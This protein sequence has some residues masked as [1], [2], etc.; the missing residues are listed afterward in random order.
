[1]KSY[2][3]SNIIPNEGIKNLTIVA[4][5]AGVIGGGIVG[6]ISQFFYLILL[7]P[8]VMGGA[9]GTAIAMTAKSSKVRN[10]MVA[11]L[12]G[13]LTAFITYA[14]MNYVQY[15]TFKQELRK[16]IIA[17]SGKSD[18]ANVEQLTNDVLKEA[19]GDTGFIGYIKFSAQQGMSI[20]RAGRSGK[21][22]SL[23]ENAT[24]IYWLIELA[25]IDGLAM[26]LAFAAAKEPFCEEG[27]DWYADK[28]WS[29]CVELSR[30]DEFL[31]LLKS[32]NY[33]QATKLVLPQEDLE[34]PRIDL[35]LQS[36]AKAPLSDLVL[37]VA[38][39]SLNSKNDVESKD[40][41]AGLITHRNRLDLF[42]DDQIASDR[43]ESY[44]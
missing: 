12:F 35:Y 31:E 32:E 8:I 14:S 4:I 34:L 6:F 30:K 38:K 21:G 43:P 3:P 40:L 2:K 29:G 37:T 27:N 13:T 25:I 26:Y 33:A 24:W 39:T 10:P 19:T 28:V 15:I 20:N 5:A 42:T 16:E 36:C 11:A 9:A 41:I 7:F 23:D 44:R 22:I 18:D 17:E 1:M